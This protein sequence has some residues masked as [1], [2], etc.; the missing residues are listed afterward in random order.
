MPSSMTDVHV[1]PH[2]VR[3]HGSGHEDG[4]VESEDALGW[5]RKSST[6]VRGLIVGGT[7]LRQESL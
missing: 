2:D 6:I 3:E 1:E 5:E 7:Q 4:G